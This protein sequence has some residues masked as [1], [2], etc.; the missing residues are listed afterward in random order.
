MSEHRSGWL[1]VVDVVFTCLFVRF[2]FFFS[3]GGAGWDCILS[4]RLEMVEMKVES[5]F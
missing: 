2:F 4:V 5:H 3:G 1:F